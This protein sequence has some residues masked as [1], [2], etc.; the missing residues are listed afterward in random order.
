MLDAEA[1]ASMGHLVE[2]LVEAVVAPYGVSAKVEHLRGVPPVVNDHVSVEV[3][4]AAARA[5]LGAEAVQPTR[6]SLGG[7]DFAWYLRSLPGAMVRLGTR[8]PGGRTYDL[9]QGDLTV[10]E[11]AVSAGAGLLAATALGCSV[12][13]GTSGT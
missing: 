9:H 11:R 1:W 6:Q 8:T 5:V 7:E 13:V 4:A 3:V 12:L 2:D 10:D